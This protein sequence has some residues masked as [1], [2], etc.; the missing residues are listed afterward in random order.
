ME[1]AWAGHCS[2]QDP[3]AVQASGSARGVS[4]V[5]LSSIS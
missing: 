3:Q 1:S 2:T 5:L 4:R